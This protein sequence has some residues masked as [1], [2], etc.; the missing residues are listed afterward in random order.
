M[1]LALSRRLYEEIII[2]DS[3]TGETIV[4]TVKRIR[5]NNVKLGIETSRQFTIRRREK[6]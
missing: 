2:T 4:I 1:P 5:R 6:P 3:K